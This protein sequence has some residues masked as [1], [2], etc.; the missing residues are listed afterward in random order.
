MIFQTQRLTI[1]PL[2]EADRTAF[3]ELMSNYNVMSPIPQPVMDKEKSDA[4]FEKHLNAQPTSDTKVMAIETKDGNA[5]I[6][7]CAYLKNNN[8]QDEIGYRLREQFW[9]I[10][11]GTETTIGLINYAFNTLN[12]ELLTADVNTA[13]VNSVKILDKFFTRD[14]EFYNEEDQCTDR[15]HTLKKE[16]WK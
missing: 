2:K 11:Y 10:G 16:D 6:G 5:F 4:N 3:F 15:R 12:L 8:N 7:I 1:R 9:G 14:F 13:N